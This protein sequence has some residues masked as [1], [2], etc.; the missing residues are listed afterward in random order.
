MTRK[1]QE[2]SDIIQ[3]LKMR[4]TVLSRKRMSVNAQFEREEKEIKQHQRHIRAL[5][6][7]MVKVNT[8]LSKQA[9]TQAILQ[10]NNLGLEHEFRCRLKDAELESVRLEQMVETL[11]EEKDKAL[12]DLIEVEH[13]ILL[14]DKKIQLAK[15]TQA[16][17]DPNVGAQEIREMTSEI[18]RMELRY[19]ALQ[20]LQEK[21]IAEMERSIT[22][23]ETIGNRSKV[24]SKG[25][26]Q[27]ALNKAIADLN[28]RLKAAMQDLRDC[29]HDIDVLVDSQERLN[30]Q[31]RETADAC[32]S[33]AKKQQELVFTIE[34]K[35]SEKAKIFTEIN[36]Y[37]KKAKRYLSIKE[38]KYQQTIK[39]TNLHQEEIQRQSEKFK[40]VEGIVDIL[41]VRASSLTIKDTNMYVVCC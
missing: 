26:N 35:L 30:L 15:E 37:Q 27:A 6:K 2:L 16:A 13:Q 23:R 24:K 12:A 29:D 41:G 1:S 17:L 39:D 19:S 31:L 21:L 40:K 18:H 38:G 22:R 32:Q 3:D 8:I 34:H 25:L 10:E 4:Q 20:K 7:D 36:F 11:K 5:Q 28:K 9:A 14:W 33:L